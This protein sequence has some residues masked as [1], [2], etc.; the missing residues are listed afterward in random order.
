MANNN[1]NYNNDIDD[2]IVYSDEHKKRI[3]LAEARANVAR[4]SKPAAPIVTKSAAMTIKPTPGEDYAAWMSRCKESAMAGDPNLTEDRA[5]DQCAVIYEENQ[6]PGVPGGLHAYH[7][8]PKKG[9]A[10]ER[11]LQREVQEK[12]AALADKVARQNEP[13][14]TKPPEPELLTPTQMQQI[15]AY[16][17]QHLAEALEAERAA[18]DE[19][20]GGVLEG[21]GNK[22]CELRDEVHAYIDA[23]FKRSDT[24]ILSNQIRRITSELRDEIRKLNPTK[25]QTEPTEQTEPIDLPNPL[26]HKAAKQL[27]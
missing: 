4:L 17:E 19:A 15:F 10:Y 11:E 20:V 5:A 14:P 6:V 9:P 7:G 13:K 18:I 12:L 1:G 2:N 27:N 21:L 25:K 26:M 3:V 16:F 23:K 24:M 8:Q 22:L